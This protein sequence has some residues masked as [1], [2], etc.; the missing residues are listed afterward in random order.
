MKSRDIHK[1]EKKNN[2]IGI[3]FFCYE[4]K[5]KYPIYISKKSCEDKHVDLL[6]I[7]K[8]EKKFY[9]FIKDFSTFMY[10]HTYVMEENIFVIIVCKLL[11][12]QKKIEISYWRLL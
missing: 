12:Q 1:I 9:V 6:L 5:V 3:S 2:S 7:G 8:G 11:E 4:N 10:D